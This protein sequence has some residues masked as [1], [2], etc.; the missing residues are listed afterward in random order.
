[1]ILLYNHFND[2]NNE[3]DRASKA[4]YLEASSQFVDS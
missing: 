1:M 2:E 3:T 4:K